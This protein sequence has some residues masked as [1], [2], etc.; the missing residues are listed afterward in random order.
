MILDSNC[1]FLEAD[2]IDRIHIEHEW[3]RPRV[4]DDERV[5]DRTG[6]ISKWTDLRQQPRAENAKPLTDY[7]TI[8]LAIRRTKATFSLSGSTIHS[9]EIAAGMSQLTYPNTPVHATFFEPCDFIHL[10]V[11]TSFLSQCT[12]TS[13][14]L[15]N[16]NVSD[17]DVGFKKDPAVEQ[18]VRSLAMLQMACPTA[19]QMYMEGICSAIIAKLISTEHSEHP[20]EEKTKISPLPKWRLKRSIEFIDANIGETITL[21]DVAGSAGL[22]RMY[23]AAQFRAATGLRPHDYI[24]RRRIERA[25][26]ILLNS[27]TTL[28]DTSLSVGFQTQAHFTTVFRKLV[29]QTPSRWREANTRRASNNFVVNIS[30]ARDPKGPDNNAFREQYAY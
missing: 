24:L 9:G 8:S 18:L 25:Q 30:G 22:T 6:I 26:E 19:R 20:V 7:Y 17:F 13:N 15:T 4:L 14:S 12:D 2:E 10:F 11:A 16:K 29:G 21:A 28:V 3:R 1:A 5:R 27:N 23:F